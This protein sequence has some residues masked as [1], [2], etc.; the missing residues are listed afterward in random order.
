MARGLSPT[1]RCPECRKIHG[2]YINS[3]GAGYYEV[4][5]AGTFDPER[6]QSS[7][8]AFIGHE[9]GRLESTEYDLKP[10]DEQLRKFRILQPAVEAL[11]GNLS[12]PNGTK[13]SILVAPTGTGKSVWAPVQIL[14]SSIGQEG[15]IC[16]TQPRLVTLRAAKGKGEETST[17]GFVA[18]QL[19]GA[20]GMG[21]GQEV[22]VLYS[23]E[24]GKQDR[25]TRLL[26]VT[27][28]ILIRWILSGQLGRFT[29]VMI[30]EAHEQSTNME[31]IFALMRYH[32]PLYPRLRLVI[33]SATM[34]V[35]RFERFFGNGQP[36]SVFVAKPTESVTLC[37]I[38]DR[39]PQGENAY[40]DSLSGFKLPQKPEDIP[41]SVAAVV[42]AIRTQLGFTKMSDPNGDIL[43]FAPTIRLVERTVE[44]VKALRFADL[45]VLPCH[46]QM[47]DDELIALSA[48]EQRATR[49]FEK[50]QN[51]K[52]QRVIVAT[53]YAET[54]VTF[55]NLRYVIESGYIMEPV[56]DP[57]TCSLDFPVRRHSQAGCTQR[58]G[59]VGRVQDGEVFRLYTREDFQDSNIFPANPRPA[60]AREPLEK[61]LLAAKAAGVA[62]LSSFD[63]LGFDGNDQLQTRERSRAMTSLQRHKV[64][65][66]DGDVTLRGLELE[67]LRS[68]SLDWSLVMS[69]SD[70]GACS[71]ELATF[72]AFTDSILSP[73]KDAADG[74][75]SWSRWRSG[76]FDDLE[77]YLRLFHNWNEARHDRSADEHAEWSKSKGLNH[78]TF[79]LMKKSRA[80]GLR[81]FAERTH[82]DPTERELDLA[83]LNRVRLVLLRG[84]SSWV[85]VRDTSVGSRE[86]RF[87]PLNPAECPLKDPVYIDRESACAASSD[88]NAFLC[89]SRRKIG[90]KIFAQHLIRVEPEWVNTMKGGGMVR[91]AKLEQSIK[92]DRKQAYAVDVSERVTAGQGA[93]CD[94]RIFR[95][96]EL[97][98]FQVL[99]GDFARD[100]IESG[101]SLLLVRDTLTDMPLLVFQE[102]GKLSSGSA[103]RAQVEGPSKDGEALLV[104]QKEL[105]SEYKDGQVI[106]LSTLKLVKRLS[107]EKDPGARS[108]GALYELEPGITALFLAP[109]S[110]SVLPWWELYLEGRHSRVAIKNSEGNLR[111]VFDF[112]EPV[113]GASVLGY[114]DG[115]REGKYPGQP[116]GMFVRLT[117]RATG[118]VHY[119]NVFG[120]RLDHYRT[121]TWIY[122]RI[123]AIREEAGKKRYELAI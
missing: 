35:E 44:A 55:T 14:R 107:D 58:K 48:S 19:L 67:R 36:G 25:Y 66:G 104:T 122:V 75:L 4:Q 71:L 18:K 51:T 28:G 3:V 96:G 123:V 33:M 41:Q 89:V 31:L 92:N 81:Q 16:V 103:F 32:L 84:L 121:G 79:K 99:R 74:L 15:R 54:G 1:T 52:P 108:H 30:D 120:R 76:C 10:K 46:A 90:D 27:D 6:L 68:N 13:V 101:R 59:R 114:I 111:L 11:I 77:F 97:R 73:F 116:V 83:R 9:E 62:D 7:G 105:L 69:F 112:I 34:D 115:F 87:V 110:P 106:D 65:D 40:A 94:L 29:V 88:V 12:D 39:W 57:N 17:P 95:S 109:K 70:E 100:E 93:A 78:K 23:G 24:G 37:E 80:E 49:A 113:P 85:Y 45:E 119:K 22:G 117:P 53:N 64:V 72:M 118:F 20:E 47:D 21:A 42:K 63:W 98:S 60:I 38:H 8:L 5:P 91:L 56:W 26:Y 2:R 43:V 82:T 50:K 86:Q 102:G 61:F